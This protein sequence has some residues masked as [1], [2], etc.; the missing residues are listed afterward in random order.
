MNDDNVFD[1]ESERNRRRPEPSMQEHL[2]ALHEQAKQPGGIFGGGQAG[3]WR[4]EKLNDG[5]FGP[6]KT[7][8]PATDSQDSKLMRNIG[9][10]SIATGAALKYATQAL[11]ETNVLQGLGPAAAVTAGLG[12]SWADQ[13]RRKSSI[14]NRSMGRN[15]R[16][17]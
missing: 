16:P 6:H 17:E 14:L 8:V 13:L 4:T 1:F 3:S 10:A 11:P 15:P 9:L 7:E 5:Q 12:M 2:D